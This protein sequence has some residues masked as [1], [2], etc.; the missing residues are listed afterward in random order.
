MIGELRF[1]SSYNKKAKYMKISD[2]VDP[3]TLLDHLFNSWNLNKPKLIISITGGAQKFDIN[4]KTKE[5]F[6]KGLLKAA[7]TTNAWIITGGT[8]FGVMRLAG[9]AVV[10]DLHFGKITLLGIA[11]WGCIAFRED[12]LVVK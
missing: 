6:K 1:P 5:A 7:K 8:N 4:L 10:E 12:L 3:S 2:K 9:D 11:T